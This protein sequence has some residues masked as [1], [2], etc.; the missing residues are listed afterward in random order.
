M[1][2]VLPK[3]RAAVGAPQAGGAAPAPEHRGGGCQKAKCHKG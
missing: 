3:G 1:W 2:P